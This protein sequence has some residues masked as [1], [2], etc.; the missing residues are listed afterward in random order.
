M[1][2]RQSGA[3]FG[4]QASV[5]KSGIEELMLG[6]AWRDF[7]EAMA[8]AM[9]TLAMADISPDDHSLLYGDPNRGVAPPGDYKEHYEAFSERYGD[10]YHAVLANTK[11]NAIWVERGTHPG[12]DEMNYVP[13]HHIM[14]RAMEGA[15]ALVRSI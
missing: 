7:C 3:D 11:R 14:A 9:K 15:F 13:G 12:G 1:A 2:G 10:H 8:F 5:N 6:N 4:I